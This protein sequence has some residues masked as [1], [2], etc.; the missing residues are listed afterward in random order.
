MFFNN[1]YV[2]CVMDAYWLLLGVFAVGLISGVF[3][4]VFLTRHRPCR[5]C[6]RTPASAEA[7]CRRGGL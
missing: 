4:G 7:Q 6:G 3:V 1:R 2:R 5:V